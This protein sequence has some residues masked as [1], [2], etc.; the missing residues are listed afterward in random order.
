M[1]NNSARGQYYKH[2]TKKWLEERGYAVAY[3]ERMHQL[4]PGVFV[5]IDQLGSDLL[6]V[7]AEET[8]FVQVKLGGPSWRQRGL[9]EA[10]KLFETF[11]V[12]PCSGQQIYVWEPGAKWPLIFQRV[13]LDYGEV[14]SWSDP[15][16]VGR[17]PLR[18]AK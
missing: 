9:S 13:R 5:K 17:L 3:M 1:A 11:P 4:K 7:N 2:K 18:R 14:S 8:L 12:P 10:R 6:A 15:E 16:E